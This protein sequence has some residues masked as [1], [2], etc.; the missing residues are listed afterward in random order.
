[1]RT[2]KIKPTPDQ[3]KFHSLQC[4][5]PAFVGGFGVGKSETMANQAFMDATH[6]PNALI[7]LYEPTYDLVR[8]I[9]APRM[10]EKLIDFG[11]RYKYNKSEN[12]IYT[13]SNQ[14]GDFI[15]RTLDNPARIVGYQ[16]YRSHVDE[17]DTLK[18]DHARDAWNKIIARNRQSIGEGSF[19]RVSAYTTPEGFRFVYKRWVKQRSEMYQMIQASTLGNPFLPE[20]YVDSL[21]ETYPD[22]LIEAYINGDFVNLSSGTVYPQFSRI[23]NNSNEE[24]QQGEKIFIGMDFNVGRMCAVVY[25]QRN[26]KAHAV[27]EFI[28]AYDTP[29]MINLIKQKY[30]REKSRGEFEKLNDIYVYPD[31]TGK[32]RKSVGAGETDISLLK[33]AG[34]NVKAKT[35]NPPVKDRVNAMNA[36]LCNSKGERVFF[37]NTRVCP[38]YTENQEQQLYNDR[39]EPEKDGT[40]DVNDAGGYYIAY[41]YP[42]IKPMWTGGFKMR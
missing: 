27:D 10:E 32:N 8:L 38:L 13:S 30:W 20:D 11:V 7:G 39:G 6:S 28:N 33:T 25:V 1:V 5:Y 14:I 42:I 12:V 41:E 4:K 19:N 18:E 35:V 29:N 3:A 21:R 24:Y 36:A 9:M 22:N 2:I 15:L 16:T 40:E 23:E 17:I 34:F 31:S 37:V 26:G